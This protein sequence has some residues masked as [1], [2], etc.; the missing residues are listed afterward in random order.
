[1]P[2][3]HVKFFADPIEVDEDEAENL[4]RHG[5]VCEPDPPPAKAPAK[6]E[7]KE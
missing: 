3:V 5:L 7:P 6:P 2:L 4:R 1:M